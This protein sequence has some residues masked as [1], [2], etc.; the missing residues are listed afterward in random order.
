MSALRK[1]L[2]G[3][4]PREALQLLSWEDAE[5]RVAG[6]KDVDIDLLKRHTEFS[7]G[8]DANAPHIQYLWNVL[9]A[10]TPEQRTAF[11]RFCYAQ[12]RLPSTDEGFLSYPRVRMLIK[13]H[14][15]AGSDPDQ[16]L[17]HADTCFFNVEIPAYSSEEVMRARLLAA[18]SVDWGMG[19]DQP[20]QHLPPVVEPQV[21]QAQSPGSRAA[22]AP[23]RSPQAVPAAPSSLSLMETLLRASA[24]A[25]D[26]PLRGSSPGSRPL[27]PPRLERAQ[28]DGSQSP[29]HWADPSEEELG[30]R[31]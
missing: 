31:L 26:A 8:V 11:V 9:R 10:F 5:E 24:A 27:A 29:L 2:Y 25:V 23:P 18:I 19:G 14:S 3:I 21:Q 4:V 30:F 15:R 7:P 22:G 1:G 28:S 16:A 13:P 17:P 12:E 20:E 6:R